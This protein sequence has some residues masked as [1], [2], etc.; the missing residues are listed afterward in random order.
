MLEYSTKKVEKEERILTKVIC[1]ICK[2]E[3]NTDN[4]EDQMQIQEFHHVR[5]M[6]GYGSI[7]GD[8]VVMESNICQYCLG[9]TLGNYMRVVE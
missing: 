2:K 3:Y 5:F 1:D 7:F 6:G 8:G 4:D 9:K